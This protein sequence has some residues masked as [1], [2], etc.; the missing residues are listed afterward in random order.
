VQ[1]TAARMRLMH[2]PWPRPELVAQRI[3]AWRV[4]SAEVVKIIANCDCFGPI[5][6]G[7]L[8]QIP[9]DFTRRLRA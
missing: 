5:A 3:A 4:N 8:E 9:V 1:R 7:N 2:R 6:L